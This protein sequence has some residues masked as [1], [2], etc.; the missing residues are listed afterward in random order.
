MHAK[1]EIKICVMQF[2]LLSGHNG[3]WSNKQKNMF[4]QNGLANVVSDYF[5][6]A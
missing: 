4:G 1:M 5:F 6:F 2:T 3:A